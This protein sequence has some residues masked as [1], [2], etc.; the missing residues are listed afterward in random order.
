MELFYRKS[1][2]QS[3]SRISC[4][5]KVA[6]GAGKS[7]AK[8]RKIGRPQVTADDISSSLLRHNSAF[9]AGKMNVPE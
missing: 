9:T 1:E 7:N 5:A 4:I 8:G 2:R 3:T 6:D